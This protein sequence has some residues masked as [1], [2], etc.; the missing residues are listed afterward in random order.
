M[1]YHLFKYDPWGNKI[2]FFVAGK[3][4]ADRLVTTRD[5]IALAV[6]VPRGVKTIINM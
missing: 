3:E 4:V 6:E 1:A 5:D 2:P